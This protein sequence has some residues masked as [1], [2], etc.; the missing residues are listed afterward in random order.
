MSAVIVQDG[1]AAR[2][3]NKSAEKSKEIQ[4]FQKTTLKYFEHTLSL[5]KKAGITK[6]Y[7]FD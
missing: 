6:S 5:L 4:D 1:R 2:G 3:V 7:D